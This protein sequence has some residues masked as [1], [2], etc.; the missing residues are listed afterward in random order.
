MFGLIE[1]EESWL[2]F[3]LDP[4]DDFGFDFILSDGLV[5]T[6]LRALEGFGFAFGSGFF[7]G[8]V[9]GLPALKVIGL[10]F[11][12][13]LFHGFEKF[14]IFF[15]WNLF[16]GVIDLGIGEMLIFWG[17]L[18]IGFGGGVWLLHVRWLWSYKNN[19]ARFDL[20]W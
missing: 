16:F 3:F 18:M 19:V 1:H 2:K 6:E 4:V 13:F 5:R 10:V 20:N 11:G 9:K 14:L 15:F 8:V 12:F 17:S 7:D